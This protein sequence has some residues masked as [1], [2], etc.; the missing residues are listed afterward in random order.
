MS[1]NKE[2]APVAPVAAEVVKEETRAA[3]LAKKK[4]APK[5]AAPAKKAVTA[6]PTKPVA[7]EASKKATPAKPAK[8]AKKATPAKKAV[9][10]KPTNSAKKATAKKAAPA[11]LTLTPVLKKLIDWQG[12]SQAELARVAGVSRVA[13]T[14]WLHMGMVGRESSFVLAGIN[15]CPVAQEKMRPDVKNL[16]QDKMARVKEQ[17]KLSNAYIKERDRERAAAAKEAAKEAAKAA[18]GR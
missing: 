15:G 1:E 4:V 16:S 10:A 18:K 7:K 5:K 2:Q 14:R 6:K 12:G 9:T 8:P 13:V 11:A 3:S 17:V